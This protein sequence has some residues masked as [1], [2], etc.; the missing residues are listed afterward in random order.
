M[1]HD[2]LLMWHWP[3]EDVTVHGADICVRIVL[4]LHVHRASAQIATVVVASHTQHDPLSVL[5]LPV[6]EVT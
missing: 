4:L 3:V 5:Q 2:P 1:Q 6:D